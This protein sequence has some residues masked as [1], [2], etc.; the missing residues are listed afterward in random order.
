[1]VDFNLL[2]RITTQ[3]DMIV[4]LFLHQTHRRMGVVVRDIKMGR[5]VGQSLANKLEDHTERQIITTYQVGLPKIEMGTN[6][7]I[8]FFLADMPNVFRGREFDLL[9]LRWAHWEDD[10][11]IGPVLDTAHAGYNPLVLY[12]DVSYVIE[13]KWGHI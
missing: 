8:E 12:G 7:K 5:G 2:G 13:R 10:H 9:W 11:V 3:E 6:C 1:M 4:S